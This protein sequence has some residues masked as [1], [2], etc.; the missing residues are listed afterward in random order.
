[1]PYSRTLIKRIQVD[2]DDYYSLLISEVVFHAD[3]RAFRLAIANLDENYYYD[4]NKLVMGQPNN[5]VSSADI[6]AVSDMFIETE[7]PSYNEPDAT[8]H[9]LIPAGSKFED[10]TA[11]PESMLVELFNIGAKRIYEDD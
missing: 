7:S 8:Y 6:K 2:V 5:I 4:P 3:E 10:Y 9:I 1:M 11:I